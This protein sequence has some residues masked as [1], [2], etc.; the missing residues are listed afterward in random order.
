MLLFQI[1]LRPN[2]HV[3]H[4]PQDERGRL[5]DNQEQAYQHQAHAQEDRVARTAEDA[6]RHQRR[7]VFIINADAPRTAHLCLRRH[8]HDDGN[9]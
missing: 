1:D 5:R 9:Q 3:A 6:V 8:H 7:G 2:E 4:Q